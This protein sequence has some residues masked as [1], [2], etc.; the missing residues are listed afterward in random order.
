MDQN[1]HTILCVDDEKNILNSLKRLL[2]K[3]DYKLL[4]ANSGLEGLK[5]IEENMVHLVICDQ[6]MTEM[7]GIDFMSL[8]RFPYPKKVPRSVN[9]TPRQSEAR[10]FSSSNVKIRRSRIS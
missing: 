8:T 10:S 6:R 1:Q 5:L 4:T 3:E 7:S 9:S 2:R